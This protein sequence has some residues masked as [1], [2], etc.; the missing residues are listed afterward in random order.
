MFG[1]CERDKLNT[2]KGLKEDAESG[3][4]VYIS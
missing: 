4:K 3:V 2:L 1:L